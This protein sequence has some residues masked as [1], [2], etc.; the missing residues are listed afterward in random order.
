MVQYTITM[1]VDGDVLKVFWSYCSEVGFD[2]VPRN[3]KRCIWVRGF[4]LAY[5]PIQFFEC[6]VC[7]GLRGNVN[8][9]DYDGCKFPS[10][11]R[12]VDTESY[13]IPDQGAEGFNRV[14]IPFI[15]PRVVDKETNTPTSA[16]P[17]ELFRSVRAVHGEPRKLDG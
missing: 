1:R 11:A 4:L 6:L 10:V 3:N 7:V 2:K 14:E 12:M 15:T 17:C 5:I 9:C 8:S 16:F 13:E